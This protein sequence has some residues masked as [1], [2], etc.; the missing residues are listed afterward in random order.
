MRDQSMIGDGQFYMIDIASGKTLGVVDA[1]GRTYGETLLAGQTT[2]VQ[3]ES[4]LIVI[5]RPAA[6]KN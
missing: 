6:L 4:K 2:I 3:A 1:G 5:Q